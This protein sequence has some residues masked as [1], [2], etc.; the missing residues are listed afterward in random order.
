MLG[1]LL[2]VLML[3]IVIPLRYK[4]MKYRFDRLE[5][6]AKILKNN[7]ENNNK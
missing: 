2:C 5:Q 4:F 7:K 6:I 3:V 1:P